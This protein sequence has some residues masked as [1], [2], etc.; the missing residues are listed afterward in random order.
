MLSAT[1]TSWA[2]W[3]VVPADRKWF[4][5]I[6][7]AAIL[8]HTLIEIG[9]QYPEVSEERRR[10]LLVVKRELEAEAP[11]RAPADPFAAKERAQNA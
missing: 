4:A 8:V 6:C 7:A 2:P 5:R 1:S 11:S 10:E 9:P 3:Y